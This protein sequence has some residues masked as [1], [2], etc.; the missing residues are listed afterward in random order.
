MQNIQKVSRIF[1]N[2]VH[3]YGGEGGI[4][5]FVKPPNILYIVF[6]TPH[7]DT[8]SE[9]TVAPS[10]VF[11]RLMRNKVKFCNKNNKL[12]E[13]KSEKLRKME[14]ERKNESI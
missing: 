3:T 8:F 9:K 11:F 5:L 6:T 7:R 1:V 10:T 12:L 13:L 14:K 2:F 4:L